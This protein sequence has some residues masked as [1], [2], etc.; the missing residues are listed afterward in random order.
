MEATFGF[1]AV[2]EVIDVPHK[3]KWDCL[4]F[5]EEFEKA[6]ESVGLSFLDYMIRR[7]GFGEWWHSWIRACVFCGNLYMLVNGYPT[8]VINI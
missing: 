1:V 7:F 8:E 4:I 5:K 2:N 3:S 6:Y